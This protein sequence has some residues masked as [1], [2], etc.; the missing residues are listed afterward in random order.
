MRFAGIIAAVALM[1]I[2]GATMAQ[3]QDWDEYVNR[4]DFLSINLPSTPTISPTQYKTA[5]GADL[6]AHVYTS[7]APADSI[8]AGT[9]RV[10]VVDYA[11]A[12]NEIGT[13]VEHAANAIKARGSVKYDGL[14][15][16]DLH[17]SRRLTVETAAER[18]LAE[19]LVAANNRLYITEA[20]TPLTSAVPANFQ[21]SLQVLDDNGT[22]I[23]TRTVLGVA[24][25]EVPAIGAGGVLDESDKLTSQ[26]AG[27]WRIAG[28]G[29]ETAYFK[30]GARVKTQRG[31]NAVAGT[32]ANAGAVIEG[33]L[34]VQGS[35]EGQFIDPATDRAVML[36]D[37]KENALKVFAVG[38]PALGWPD[39]ALEHCAG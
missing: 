13:A 2:S 9:Y 36:F 34:I 14:N 1:V 18:T 8:L 11:G 32:I 16:I 17:V 30:S 5:K 3:S 15:Q 29:C 39:A 10:T 25:E 22:R 6:P 12:K 7:Q 20:I 33:Q 35:R 31:E 19:I 27:A 38:A 26:V 21:A 28:G 37:V 24:P 23:R 4:E